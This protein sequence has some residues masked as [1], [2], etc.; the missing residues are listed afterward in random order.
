MGSSTTR[1]TVSRRKKRNRRTAKWEADRGTCR[2]GQEGHADRPRGGRAVGAGPQDGDEV[3]QAER[4][5]ERAGLWIRVQNA[6]TSKAR[7]MPASHAPSAA[8]VPRADHP[9]RRPAITPRAGRPLTESLDSRTDRVTDP[10]QPPVT[11]SIWM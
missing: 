5:L 3:V 8:S 2:G 7:A 4:A 6:L 9:W 1:P 11:A 10:R